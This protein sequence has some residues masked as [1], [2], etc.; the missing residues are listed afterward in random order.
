M[1]SL[2]TLNK[3]LE[4]KANKNWVMIRKNDIFRETEDRMIYAE[5][6]SKELETSLT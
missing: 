5:K 2:R 1:K 3:Q 6:R 4:N